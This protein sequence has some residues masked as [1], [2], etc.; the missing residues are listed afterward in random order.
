MELLL[1]HS[2]AL[3]YW[4]IHGTEL[5]IRKSR[6]RSRLAPKNPPDMATLH[7][8]HEG[9]LSFP[10]NVLVSLENS[11]RR[12]GLVH[13]R[14]LS[15]PMPEG[16]LVDVGDGI[17]VSS[18]EFCFLQMADELQFLK[19]IELGY[20]LCGSYCLPVY[21]TDRRD[22]PINRSSMKRDYALTSVRKLTAFLNRMQGFTANQKALKP[23]PYIADSSASPRETMVAMM[24][25]LP[26]WYGGYGFPLPVMNAKIKP[27][28]AAKQSSSK[29]FYYCDLFWDD[30]SLSVEYDSDEYHTG[31]TRIAQ[32]SMK[33]NSLISVDVTTVTITRMQLNSMAGFEKIAKQLSIYMEK[34]LQYK[35]PQFF[36]AQRKLRDSLGIT[37]DWERYE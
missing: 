12:S 21:D 1:T 35:E 23:L 34:R 14:L 31:S 15:D 9:G 26:Y 3:E 20:E 4:R 19:L 32:D 22:L 16:C 2:S 5:G 11:R 28:G 25:T 18:P 7:K 27:A 13:S 30:F 10:I 36:K 24:L 33:R 17:F 6:V 37:P 8:L 29:E